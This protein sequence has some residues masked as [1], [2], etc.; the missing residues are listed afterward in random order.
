LDKVAGFQ[1]TTMQGGPASGSAERSRAFSK[2]RRHS[3]WVRVAK[4]AI[5]LSAL[6]ALTGVILVAYLDPFRKIENLTFGEV[7]VSG[8]N[9]TMESPKLTGF[10][11]DNR[12]YEVTASAATQDV[13]KPNFVELKDLKA[14]IVTDDKGSAAHMEAAI[15]VL[16]TQK[17]RL[18]LKQNVRVITDGGQEVRLRSALVNFKAGSVVSNEPV[19]VLLGTSGQIE[20]EGLRVIDNGKVMSFKGRVRTTFAPANSSDTPASDSAGTGPKAP[21]AQPTSVRP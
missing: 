3:R 1:G 14:R 19:T 7:G 20:A 5:P 15:G 17:E 18:D 4:I 10:K 21:A 2:A 12:P 11:N 9:V 13:R 8:T 6:I 16:D